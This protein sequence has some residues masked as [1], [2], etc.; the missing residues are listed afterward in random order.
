LLLFFLLYKQKYNNY[1]KEKLKKKSLL[2][3]TD[4]NFFTSLSIS[5]GSLNIVQRSFG[6]SSNAFLYRSSHVGKH[7]GG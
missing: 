2:F 6:T 1:K 3:Y 7:V 4:T 5:F